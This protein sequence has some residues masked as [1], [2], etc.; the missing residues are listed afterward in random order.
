MKYKLKLG[1]NELSF[2]IRNLAAQANG[3]VLVRY[4]DTTVLVTAVMSAQD[5]DDLGFFPLT[6]DFEEKYYAAGKILGSR[7]MKREGRPS[8][9][10]ILNGR[11]IDRAIRPRFPKGLKRAVQVIITC[12]SWDGENDPDILGLLGAS[13]ALSI[14]DIPWQE[15]LAAARI[16]YMNGK[17]VLNPTYKEREESQLDLFLSGIEKDKQLLI[18]MLEAKAEEINEEIFLEAAQ[19][20][21]APLKKLISFQE[22]I[23]EK[24]GKE[25][26]VVQPTPE[27]PE[28]EKEIKKF[29]GERLEETLFCGGKA[30]MTEGL[31]ELKQELAYFTEGKYPE[32]GKTKYAA[33]FFEQETDRLLHES[34]SKKEKRPDGRKLNELRPLDCEV[35]L[36]PRTHGSGLFS[37]G[38]TKAL[39]ILTLGAP[40]DQQ[41]LQGMEVVGKKRF[42]HHYNFPPYSVGE[43]KPL[44]GPARR[45]I[46]HGMLAEKGLL[47]IIPSFEEFPYTIRIVSE[48]VSSNGSSSMA[49]ISSSSLALMDAGVP[50]KRPS[51]GIA[52]G[53]IKDENGG[54]K[55]LTDI[56]GP[57]DHHGDM[58]LKIAG[59]SQGI[60]VA[61]M[62]VKIDGISKEILER[63]LTQ[64]KTARKKI[65][66]AMEKTIAKPRPKLSPYAPCILRLQ[67]NPEKIGE[68][69]GP[70]GKVIREITEKCGVE[71]DIE[72]DGNVFITAEKAE[73]GN[74]ALDWVK[75]ITREAKIGEKFEG[76]VT[77]IF[78]FGAM[79]EI[80]PGQEGL[81][82][83]VGQ[84][85]KVG[86]TVSVKIS[87]IDAQS[88]INLS[89]NR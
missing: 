64:A 74:K 35:G 65:L 56:Q 71:I 54:Y 79:V 15:P 80:F 10:A 78:D 86:Q 21:E 81:V 5:R 75:N 7:Y 73:A 4:G 69:I 9:K 41:L 28:L 37:R 48:I 62:D 70:G 32:M 49:S 40:G 51:A 34:I 44:R 63:A 39:S 85:L 89:L 83:G 12:L 47:S 29:L 24:I 1:A 88:R 38:K 3:E 18:N 82:R 66:E 27:E 52:L 58:D 22:E 25:K 53:L 77:R 36:L 72:E 2:E 68:V 26:L 19:K 84:T 67:I 45:D 59:T 50:I 8:D 46:G 87:S 17:F 61:Q 76:K 55:I 6:V 23:K 31:N 14:S 60:T 11:L 33:D 43:V 30:A 42:M 57:E 20:A 16:G 13:L